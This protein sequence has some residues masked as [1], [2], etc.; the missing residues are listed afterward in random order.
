MSKVTLN[1]VKEN[2]E[3][4]RYGDLF[5]WTEKSGQNKGKVCLLSFLGLIDLTNPNS[6]WTTTGDLFDYI[7]DQISR[8]VLM[9]LP[10]G[11]SVLIEQD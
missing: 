10:K 6:T 11:Y 5:E 1:P 7:R 9:K 2:D 3:T 4:I 8:G